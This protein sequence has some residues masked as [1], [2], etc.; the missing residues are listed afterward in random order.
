MTTIAVYGV[1]RVGSVVA[2]IALAA[3]YRVHVA[4]SGS[5]ED[6]ALLTEIMMP[7][8]IPSAARDAAADAEVVVLALPLG[9]YRTVDP[10][11]LRGKIV[12]DAMNY[13]A[14]LDGVVDDFEATTSTTSEVVQ[15]AFPQ[16]RVVKSLNHIG[17]HDM[18]E[19]GTP[20]GTP[21]RRALAVAS[22]DDDAAQVVA[23]MIDRLGFDA[24]LAGGLASGRAF[25]PGTAIFKG[26]FDRPQM[27][28]EL[29][30]FLVPNG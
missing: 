5:A 25:Q 8:A 28:R 12:V 18:E 1:G 6:I 9:K 29:A 3:G 27:Q 21:G 22:D 13:W 2:K 10:A 15:A 16:S 7:G 17:Y 4:G 23:A 30:A 20:T 19:Q 26:S 14:P 11:P 24:C